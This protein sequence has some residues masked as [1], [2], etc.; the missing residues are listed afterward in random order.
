MD[1]AVGDVVELKSGGPLMTIYNFNNDRT[2]ALCEWF[3][4][5]GGVYEHK[6]HLF[7][8]DVLKKVR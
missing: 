6:E 4:V 7:R 3:N 2:K 8:V 1:L 5:T